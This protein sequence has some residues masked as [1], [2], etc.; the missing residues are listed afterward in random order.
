MYKCSISIDAIR[1]TLIIPQ[2]SKFVKNK[3]LF[4]PQKIRERTK[5]L[6]T[7]VLDALSGK[8]VYFHAMMVNDFFFGNT[9][10]LKFFF[11]FYQWPAK[12]NLGGL[13]S[14]RKHGK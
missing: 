11:S 12:G 3:I 2:N 8:E 13:P 4:T 10:Y 9:T 6:F 1:Q 14:A 7:T 5:L